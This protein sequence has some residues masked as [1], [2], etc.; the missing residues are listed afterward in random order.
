MIEKT[1]LISWIRLKRLTYNFGLLKMTKIQIISDI[2]TEHYKDA[3]GFKPSKDAEIIVF[4]GDIAGSPEQAVSF[5]AGLRKQTESIFLYVLGNHE[6]FNFVFSDTD[7][8]YKRAVKNI[9]DLYLLDRK[10]FNHNGII[11]SG[12]T[13]WTDYDRQRGIL[14]ALYGMIDFQLI[15]KNKKELI[16]PYMIINEHKKH[17]QF[18]ETRRNSP[19]EKHVFITHH[20]P[21]FSLVQPQFKSSTLNGSFA[22]DLDNLILDHKPNLWVCGHTHSYFDTQIEDTRI[23]CNPIGYPHEKLKIK[24][25]LIDL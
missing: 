9:K 7:Q 16:D 3:S 19:D 24:E 14:S 22:V 5:F 6:Y 15:Y 18:L 11:F 12:C 1:I 23:I 20:I 25:V 13:L 4:A 2:H 10:S 8:R 21:S 17:V